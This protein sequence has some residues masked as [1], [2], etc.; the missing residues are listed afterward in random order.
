MSSLTPHSPYSQPCQASN[1]PSKPNFP[2]IHEDCGKED[3]TSFLRLNTSPTPSVLHPIQIPS[4]CQSSDLSLKSRFPQI[5]ED[6][7]DEVLV[8]PNCPIDAYPSFGST[9]TYVND[10]GDSV[11]LENITEVVGTNGLVT[12]ETGVAEGE[13]EVITL[14]YVHPHLNPLTSV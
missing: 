6:R 2:Q 14:P 11:D 5:F 8:S 4:N 12:K 10:A 13:A 9:S 1:I 7:L 3:C